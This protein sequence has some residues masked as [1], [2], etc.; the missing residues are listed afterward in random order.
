MVHAVVIT[1]GR[2][3]EELLK[4][5]EMIAGQIK[6]FDN[7]SLLKEDNPMGFGE[8]I[9]Q[10]LDENERELLFLADLFGGTPYNTAVELLRDYDAQIITGVNLG[11]ILELNSI[12]ETVDN[13]KDAVQDLKDIFEFTCQVVNRGTLNISPEDNDSEEN[14]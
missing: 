7:I 6:N 3:G 12:M 5:A 2:F 9:R 4:S 14:L 1:H 8:K 10:V 11:M 13:A